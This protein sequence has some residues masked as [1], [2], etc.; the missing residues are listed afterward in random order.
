MRKFKA[1]N[2]WRTESPIIS[3]RAKQIG[4]DKIADLIRKYR[5]INKFNK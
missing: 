4:I 5:K 2:W 3:F 1:L